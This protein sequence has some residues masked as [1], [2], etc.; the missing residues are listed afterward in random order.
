MSGNGFA[1]RCQGESRQLE[2]L[3]TERYSY[4]CDTQ[5]RAEKKMSNR[6]PY[7]ANKYPQQIH[8]Y[9]QTSAIGRGA[10]HFHTKRKKSEHCQL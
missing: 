7:T 5:Q 1:E 3:N 8:E 2:V 4:H 6:N 10:L 9:I